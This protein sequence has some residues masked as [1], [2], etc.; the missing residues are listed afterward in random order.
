MAVITIKHQ[1]LGLFTPGVQLAAGFLALFNS[2]YSRRMRLCVLHTST[3][4]S[5]A[6]TLLLHCCSCITASILY[7]QFDRSYVSGQIEDDCPCG[8]TR[9]TKK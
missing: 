9:E 2:S 3:S 6:A 1:P 4:R 7:M 8:I 5:S